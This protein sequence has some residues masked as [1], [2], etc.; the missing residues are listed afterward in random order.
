VTKVAWAG[1]AMEMT[2]MA[3][4][5]HMPRWFGILRRVRDISR[6]LG[7]GAPSAAL[8]VWRSSAD[9]ETIARRIEAFVESY[10]AAN[11]CRLVGPDEM[12]RTVGPEQRSQ[13]HRARTWLAIV[14]MPN[15][16][17]IFAITPDRKSVGIRC[18][19][20]RSDADGSPGA[21]WRYA[22]DDR[23]P[24]RRRSKELI[25]LDAFTTH[26]IDGSRS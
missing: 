20:L 21:V 12:A 13:F 7:A 23:L 24:Q 26:V 2:C 9:V 10:P 8:G 16:T 5:G 25:F 17:F 19:V 3:G 15:A 14:T 1:G 6:A 4:S 18:T 22:T 11:E